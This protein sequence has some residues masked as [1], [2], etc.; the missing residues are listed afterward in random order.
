MHGAE[1]A[2]P[3]VGAAVALALLLLARALKKNAYEV[4]APYKPGDAVP[5]T[6]VEKLTKKQAAAK[7]KAGYKVEKHLE[8]KKV[9]K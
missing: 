2:N 8:A 7:I 3:W 9:K 5:V 4:T 1:F 6:K